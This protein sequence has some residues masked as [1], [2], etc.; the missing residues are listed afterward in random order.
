MEHETVKSY[1]ENIFIPQKRAENDPSKYDISSLNAQDYQSPRWWSLRWGWTAFIPRSLP[2]FGPL[3]GFLAHTPHVYPVK[4]PEEGYKLPVWV[5][6]EMERLEEDLACAICYLC[7]Q[8][9]MAII[10]PVLPFAFGYKKLH[11]T[12]TAALHSFEKARDWYIIWM[13]MFSPLPHQMQEAA[14]FLVVQPTMEPTA[15]SEEVD[16]NLNIKSLQHTDQMAVISSADASV[17]R[18]VAAASSSIV[19]DPGS[20]EPRTS[21]YVTWQ[22]FFQCR[23]KANEG[24][25]ENESADD[26][27][28]RL[29][30]E[31]RPPT[32]KYDICEEFGPGREYNSD[33]D[34]SDYPGT[35]KIT[36]E[37]LNAAVALDVAQ[38]PDSNPRSP[39][40]EHQDHESHVSD[41]TLAAQE[42]SKLVN[43]EQGHDIFEEEILETVRVWFGFILPDTG[44]LS[45]IKSLSAENDQKNFLKLLGFPW[46]AASKETLFHPSIA[47]AARFLKK[48]ISKEKIQDVE[49]DLGTG[50][51]RSLSINRRFAC[52][53]VVHPDG[54][55]SKSLYLFDFG[56]RATE[57]WKICMMSVSHALMLCRLDLQWKEYE[58]AHYLVQNGIP[59]RTLQLSSTVRRAPIVSKLQQKHPFHPPSYTFTIDDYHAYLD[60]CGELLKSPH[61]RAALLTGGYIWRIAISS[62][63]LDSVMLGPTGWSTK[64]E[65][66][67]VVREP[68]TGKE[69][70]DDQL[71]EHELEILSG[72]NICMMGKANSMSVMSH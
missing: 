9:R 7:A 17:E 52:I 65:E 63:S 58:L 45:S 57:P 71:T 46:I 26:K 62:V 54:D 29:N 55:K 1:F 14:T 44:T 5:I 4:E 60:R 8:L 19:A 66:M 42:L 61:G 48:L 16:D 72:L 25:M 2:F 39:C 43:L 12:A 32:H 34:G 33:D 23:E 67:L 27:Q 13:G 56:A 38:I 64:P 40:V 18:T 6:E 47:A 51:H 36:E 50:H 41:W 35:Y 20:S 3:F 53:R 21:E 59:F 49:W 15:I 70:I 24:I 28:R 22:E 31:W 69:Y 11:K 37:Q 30:R 68:S 10:K